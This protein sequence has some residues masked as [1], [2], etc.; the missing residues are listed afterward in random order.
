MDPLSSVPSLLA[1]SVEDA[2]EL[3]SISRR[4]LYRHVRAGELVK[5]KSGSRT[6]IQRVELVRFLRRQRA[7]GTAPPDA[8]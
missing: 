7:A 5:C 1:Y 6:V 8:A 2:A 3:L 4:Q